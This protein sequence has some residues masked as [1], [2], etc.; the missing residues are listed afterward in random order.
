M[1]DVTDVVNDERVELVEPLEFFLQFQP[2]LGPQEPLNQQRTWSEVDS[3]A[4]Q[5]EFMPEGAQQMGLAAARIPEGQD[6]LGALQ[7]V[8]VKQCIHASLDGSGQS[9]L[10][11]RRP[12]LLPGQFRFPQE[13]F[14][15]PLPPFFQFQFTQRHQIPVVGPTFVGRYSGL[16]VV[17]VDEGRQVQLAQRGGDLCLHSR[18]SSSTGSSNAS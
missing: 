3:P 14:G 10:F 8:S 15:L 11:K 1:L 18:A 6:V 4:L 7:E 12:G 13:P 2:G 17:V 16:N 5:D 9:K